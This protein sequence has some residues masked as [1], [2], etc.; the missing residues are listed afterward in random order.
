M[1]QVIDLVIEPQWLL[2]IRPEV[3][4]LE[5]QAL[6][7]HRGEIVA[8]G[9][10]AD[11][12]AAWPAKQTLQLPGHVLLPGLI[13]AH[14]HASMTLLRGVGDDM[15]LAPWLQERIWPVETALVDPEFVAC[16]TELAIAE[17]LRGGTTCANEMYFF[18]DVAAHT[19]LRMGFRMMVGLI[20][21]DFPSAWAADADTYF[22]R[23]LK[24]HDELRGEPLLSTTLAPHAPYTVGDESFR[25]IHTLSDQL[26]LPVTT[27]LHETAHEVAESRKLHGLRPFD[28]LRALNLVNENLRAVH[29]TQMTE[30]EIEHCAHAG[31]TVVHCPESNL[32]L[33]SGLC[34]VQA[35]REAGV[36]VALG[37]DGA[38]SNNDLDMF[39]EMRTA[40]LIGKEAAADATAVPASYALEMAT[41]NGAQ[42]LGL[43]DRI[44][45]LEVGKRADM[46][47]VALHDLETQP[48]YDVVS[49]LVYAS[50]R[51]MVRHVWVDGQHRVCDGE[52]LGLDVAALGRRIVHWRQRVDEALKQ[53]ET[54]E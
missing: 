31:V 45:S 47:A 48:L 1:S 16:G 24:L 44:G 50:S 30:G 18:P 7:V 19:A 26:D 54:S 17:M 37:T 21:L 10:K 12:A 38:A 49:Q 43:S 46:V 4:A 41:I 6:A 28:R 11:V 5:G 25:R 52:L 42:A 14:T 35:L 13:N 39:G 53:Q 3:S 15:A 20:V 36:N 34:P 9:N 40:A 2:P 27:H 51:A 8:L 29:M 33:A 32:K 23:G 22:S